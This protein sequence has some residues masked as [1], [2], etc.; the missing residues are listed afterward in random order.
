MLVPQVNA[1][2]DNRLQVTRDQQA[3]CNH[4]LCLSVSSLACWHLDIFL[5]NVNSLL[6]TNHELQNDSQDMTSSNN[7][8]Q[9][10]VHN[11]HLLLSSYQLNV[12]QRLQEIN[13]GKEQKFDRKKEKDK[14]RE[15]QNEKKLNL[16]SLESYSFLF[17]LL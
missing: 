8:L 1:Q 11:L 14:Q 9:L 15:I 12:N 4:I 10:S 6:K 13:K 16:G 17:Y 3:V 2:D 5:M 7:S